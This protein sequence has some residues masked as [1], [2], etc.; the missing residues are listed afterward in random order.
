MEASWRAA[1]GLLQNLPPLRRE[2]AGPLKRRPSRTHGPYPLPT[3]PCPPP[4]LPPPSLPPP[5]LYRP[6][7]PSPPPTPKQAPSRAAALGSTSLICSISLIWICRYLPSC[8]ATSVFSRHFHVSSPHGSS[9][10]AWHRGVGRR[11]SMGRLLCTSLDRGAAREPWAHRQRLNSGFMPHLSHPIVYLPHL[12][13]PSSHPYE[14]TAMLLI[15]NFGEQ[16]ALI[17]GGIGSVA[18][19]SSSLTPNNPFHICHTPIFLNIDIHRP[20]MRYRFFAFLDH[21]ASLVL[22]SLAWRR[23]HQI[24]NREGGLP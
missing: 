19:E 13:H 6:P 4:F 2:P 23:R 5:S 18:G 21:A 22:V 20:K 11:P 15:S 10:T 14:F 16:A 7:P 17:G 9:C 24:R 12:A 8:R 1:Q 3:S